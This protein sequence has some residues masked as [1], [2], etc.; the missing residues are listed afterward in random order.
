M[1]RFALAQ[2]SRRAGALAGTCTAPAQPKNG[3][4]RRQA[5]FRHT[6][7]MAYSQRMSDVY[8]AT[9]LGGMSSA[10]DTL[11]DFAKGFAKEEE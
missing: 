8:N 4:A 1:T 7:R 2:Y 6:P 11:E 10:L 3:L 9:T 5:A